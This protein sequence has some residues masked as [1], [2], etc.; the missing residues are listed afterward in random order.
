MRRCPHCHTENSD[1]AFFCHL[2]GRK[3][4]NKANGWLI[5]FIIYFLITC[6]LGIIAVGVF[7]DME[8]EIPRLETDLQEKEAEILKLEIL[9]EENKNDKTQLESLRRDAEN[10]NERLQSRVWEQESEISNLKTRVPQLYTTKYA[11][12]KIYYWEG[13][14]KETTYSYKKAGVSVT[15][16]FWKDGYGLTEWGWIP[17]DCLKK[18]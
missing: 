5:A 6:V 3:I 14:F 7:L 2:C 16:Y 13:K 1:D 10:E 18:N 8:S 4:K 9:V 12:Q 17:S 15:V 11:N